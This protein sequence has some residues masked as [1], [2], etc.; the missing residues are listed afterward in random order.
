MGCGPSV[1]KA[2]D[3]PPAN[4]KPSTRNITSLANFP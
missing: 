3:I 1:K 2:Q 4:A